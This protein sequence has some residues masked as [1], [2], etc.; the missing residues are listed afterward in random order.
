[1]H[2]NKSQRTKYLST[3]K[4]NG[5]INL[6]LINLNK[7]KINLTLIHLLVVRTVHDT[8]YN[9]WYEGKWK[10]KWSFSSAAFSKNN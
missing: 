7:S 2:T 3:L 1:M 4:G 6:R 5:H 10:I 8:C 9:K